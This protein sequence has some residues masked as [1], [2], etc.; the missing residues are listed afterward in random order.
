MDL[1]TVTQL[2]SDLVAINSINPDLIPGAPGEAEIADY[3]ARWLTAAGLEVR[4]DETVPNRPNV[5]GIARGTGGGK[6]L[7]LNGHMDTVGVTGMTAPHQP[8]IE[9]G[10]LFGRG[11]YDMKGGLAAAMLAAAA[12]KQSNLRGDVIF[13]AVMDEEFA[14][15]GTMSIA[16]Q[17]HADAAVIAEPTELQLVVAHKGFVWLDVETRG[18]AAHGSRPDLGVDAIVAIGRVLVGLEQLAQDL[19]ARPSHPLLGNPS[20]HASLIR[21]GQEL[22]SYP[23]HCTLAVE[24]R[25][26]PGETPQAVEQEIQTILSA[27]ADSDPK[28]Q[29]TVHRGMDRAPME[30][31]SDSHIVQALLAAANQHLPQA[32]AVTAVP[33]WTDA[34]TLTAAGIPSVLF[35]PVGAGAHAVQEWVDLASVQ[36]SAEIYLATA[37]AFCI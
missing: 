28:F 7:M 23:D 21:G 32:C 37:R 25:T 13:T 26:L 16:R 35:G 27:I 6:T 17:Y 30:T 5:I 8:R 9:N 19:G 12:A 33:Y 29:A 15:A 2:V 36:T 18:V 11:G 34:A 31:P 24:R 1:Q 10:K 3:I 14:G 20:I 4:R 22:S